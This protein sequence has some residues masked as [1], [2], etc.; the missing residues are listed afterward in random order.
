M[1]E[2]IKY[3]FFDVDG[4]LTRGEIIYTS[5]GEEIKSFNVKD[6]LGIM[7][8]NKAGIET[9]ILTARESKVVEKRAKELRMTDIFT[10]QHDKFS[11]YQELLKN[12]NLKPENIAYIGDDLIDLKVLKNCA[13]SA[14][15][16]DAVDEVKDAVDLVTKRKGGEGAVREFCE[17]I[18]KRNGLWDNII[19]SYN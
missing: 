2:M 16:Q 6:G 15:P 9:G 1:R 5:S 8:L 10:G 18:L 14:A 11:K 7:L 3:V 12:K 17:A 19:E 4:V 13:F